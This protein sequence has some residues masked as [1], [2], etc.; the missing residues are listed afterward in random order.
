MGKRLRWRSLV[1]GRFCGKL[2]FEIL[3]FPGMENYLGLSAWGNIVCLCFLCRRSRE[4]KTGIDRVYS[5]DLWP[6]PKTQAENRAWRTL[7]P[8]LLS[9][10]SGARCLL[11]YRLTAAAE[12]MFDEDAGVFDYEEAGGA[13]FGG[14]V[15]VFD[16][17]L[18]PDYFCAD[19]DGA[20]DDGWD[21]FG[22]EKN[23]ANFDV[24]S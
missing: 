10:F 21:V 7:R 13:G 20:V 1:R 2:G 3:L 18:H 22:A 8:I 5:K 6:K 12:A 23:I 11:T 15:L 4:R 24:S 17:L 16:S 9:D 19:C 14:G